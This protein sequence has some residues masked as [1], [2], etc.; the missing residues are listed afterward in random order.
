MRGL[1]LS[2]PS[3]PSPRCRCP[4]SYRAAKSSMQLFAPPCHSQPRGRRA[5]PRPDRL[6]IHP[7]PPPPQRARPRT[8]RRP[9]P[10]PRTSLP[11]SGARWAIRRSRVQWCRVPGCTVHTSSKRRPTA[12]ASRHS[13]SW[14]GRPG[15]PIDSGAPRCQRRA[16]RCQPGTPALPN[17]GRMVSN[18]VQ[19]TELGI[20]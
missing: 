13:L 4:Q 12:P 8:R 1:P 18:R 11:P 19:S 7:P 20:A 16:P 17:F 3:S 9:L 5:R 2:Q 14:R 15:R 6:S 10:I